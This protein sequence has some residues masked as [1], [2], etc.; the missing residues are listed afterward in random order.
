MSEKENIYPLVEVIR[1][2]Y[3]QPCTM[4]TSFTNDTAITLPTSKEISA[5]QIEYEL[6]L[7]AIIDVL[8]GV[9]YL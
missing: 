7:K 2:L 4:H 3:L 1:K 5:L 8:D 9:K 6:T